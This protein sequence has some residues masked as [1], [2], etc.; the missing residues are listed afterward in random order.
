[1]GYSNEV[2]AKQA[3][4]GQI[5]GSAERIDHNP[6]VLENIDTR[7]NAMKAEI[8]RLEESKMSLAPLLNMRISDIRSAMNY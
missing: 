8:A 6:T 2:A 5:L 3:H 1:M 7:I 4:Y